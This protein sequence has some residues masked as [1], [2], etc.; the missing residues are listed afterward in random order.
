MVGYRERRWLLPSS[1]D[2]LEQNFS[3]NAELILPRPPRRAGPTAD[4]RPPRSAEQEKE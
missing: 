3:N 4:F 2:P 1:F